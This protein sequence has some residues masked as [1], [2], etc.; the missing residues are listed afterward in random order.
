MKA[1]S[2]V[3]R[4]VGGETTERLK[5]GAYRERSVQREER[6]SE[7]VLKGSDSL[8]GVIERT[9]RKRVAYRLDACCRSR[10]SRRTR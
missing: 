9:R 8:N 7:S 4:G 5:K 2:L 3:M 1:S 6:I 10:H